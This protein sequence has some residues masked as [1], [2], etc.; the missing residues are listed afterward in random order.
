AIPEKTAVFQNYPN[1]F[2]PE[3]WIPFQLTED[4]QANITIYSSSGL[5]IRTLDMGY[6]EAG[7]YMDKEYAA[8]WDGRSDAGEEVAS[9]IYFY[10]IQAGDLNAVRKMILVR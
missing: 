10:R 3:T 1:P 5:L 8:Y 6:R 4:A 7:T 9:G 2:N